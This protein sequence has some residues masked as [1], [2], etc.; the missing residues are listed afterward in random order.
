[1]NLK[2]MSDEMV[3]QSSKKARQAECEALT[4]ILHH[5]HENERRRL[6]AKLNYP[7]LFEYAV[8][9]LKYSEA[10]AM[11]R[12]S[13]M[14]LMKEIPE[15]EGKIE[16]GELSLTNVNLAHS[17]FSKERKEGR[18]LDVVQKAEVL[19][20]LENLS[21][22]EAERVVFEI[23]PSMKKRAKALDY[24]MIDD[25]G[26][27]T[28]LLRLKGKFAHTNP[29]ISLEELMHKLCDQALAEKPKSETTESFKT[30]QSLSAP[31]V[32]S[33]AETRRQ[34]WRR[35]QCKCTKC[36]STYALEIDHVIPRAVGGESTL[37]NMRLLC[38]S[39]NQRAAIEYFGVR[40]MSSYLN[41]LN[42]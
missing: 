41:Q 36:D 31:K 14:R 42:L 12:I 5:L 39:C 16:S 10:Q 29:N 22:R 17:L 38:R 33:Q 26:L 40:K 28:K 1:M 20:R 32:I 34:V 27:R 6:Y 8:K 19:H 11:R 24:N 30:K 23:S 18:P 2:S 21:S 35:D 7:S 25:D 15:V 4:S 13:A 37:T 3:L 9:E